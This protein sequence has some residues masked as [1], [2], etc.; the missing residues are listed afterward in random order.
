VTLKVFD[1]LGREVAT[2]VNEPKN[3]GIYEVTWDASNMPSGMYF[4]RMK[5]GGT[6]ETRK[7]VM[8]R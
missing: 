2:L 1:I 8:L 6:M 3:P 5:A 7:L 4:Y